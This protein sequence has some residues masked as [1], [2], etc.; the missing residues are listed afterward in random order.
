ML[1]AN[2][3]RVRRETVKMQGPFEG[4]NMDAAEESVYKHMLFFSG[5][6]GITGILPLLIRAVRRRG[7]GK[8][9]KDAP[10]ITLVHTCRAVD[11]LSVLAPLMPYIEHID[12]IVNFTGAAHLLE[13]ITLEAA[14]P[15]TNVTDTAKRVEAGKGK[16]AATVATPVRRKLIRMIADHTLELTV[17]MVVLF[18]TF[19]FTV[20]P[21]FVLPWF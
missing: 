13:P 1:N 2:E 15:A 3:G 19:W 18:M 10:R 17:F 7:N 11:E 9:I 6:I 4:E 5:G 14:M 16:V 20:R 8:A 21:R 12:L